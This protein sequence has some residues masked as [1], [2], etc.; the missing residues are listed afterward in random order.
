MSM[1]PDRASDFVDALLAS[2]AM[3]RQ[4]SYLSRGRAYAKVDAG[5]LKALWIDSLKEWLRLRTDSSQLTMEDFES[6]FDLRE[7]AIPWDA[8]PEQREQMRQEVASSDPADP[9]VRKAI[10]DFMDKMDDPHG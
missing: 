2:A 8:V 6:E 1:S 10:R 9:G 3:D 7:I 4:A 5:D